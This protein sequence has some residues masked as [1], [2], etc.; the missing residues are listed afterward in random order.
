MTYLYILEMCATLPI[1]VFIHVTHP[2]FQSPVQ[3]SSSEPPSPGLKLVNHCPLSRSHIPPG[4]TSLGHESYTQLPSLLQ[5]YSFHSATHMETLHA[6]TLLGSIM[7]PAQ[8]SIR[9][10]QKEKKSS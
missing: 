5:Y 2:R 3:I 6:P 7:E 1:N 10:M 9:G 4:V 8:L